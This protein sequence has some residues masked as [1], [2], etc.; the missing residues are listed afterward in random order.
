MNLLT[1]LAQ[2]QAPV[3][4]GGG[5]GLLVGGG[6]ILVFLALGLIAL[7][8]WLWALIDAIRNPSLSDTERIV[9]VIVILLTSWL[10]A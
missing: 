1:L 6:M 4:G 8:F 2:A 9:W 10:G 3:D 7:I 5:A